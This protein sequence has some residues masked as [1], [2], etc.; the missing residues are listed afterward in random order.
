VGAVPLVAAWLA[1]RVL[2]EVMK[3]PLPAPALPVRCSG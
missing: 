2:A 1:F 3:R